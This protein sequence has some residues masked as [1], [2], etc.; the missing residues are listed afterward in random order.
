MY[1]PRGR[2]LCR[3]IFP[4]AGPKPHLVF[5]DQFTGQFAG[6]LTNQFSSFYTDLHAGRLPTKLP[7]VWFVSRLIQW[8][9]ITHIT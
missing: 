3:L 7:H 2:L 4:V 1:W 9:W 5:T 8:N 6:L